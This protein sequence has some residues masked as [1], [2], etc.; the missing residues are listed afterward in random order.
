MKTKIQN[1]FIKPN[2]EKY[3]IINK[4]KN[5]SHTRKK[6]LLCASHYII[7]LRVRPSELI[8]WKVAVE[9]I[10]EIFHKLTQKT[11]E[12]LCCGQSK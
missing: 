5:M 12:V 3:H 8:K 1:I 10:V 2:S 6:C 9:L 7:T 4:Y 11:R